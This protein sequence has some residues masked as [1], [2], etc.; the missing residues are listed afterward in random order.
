M[1]KHFETLLKAYTIL[2]NLTP[3]KYDCGTLCSSL[4]CKNNSTEGETLGMWLLPYEK[5]L[6]SA[7]ISDDE[8][9]EF[10]F[11]KA[12]DGTE[13]VFCSGRCNRQFRPFACRIYPYYVN[14]TNDLSGGTKVKIKV[15][16]RAKLSCP[17]A[18]N[19]SYLRPS[20]H[21][22][23]GVKDAVRVL[24]KDEKIKKDLIATS[25]FLS[26]IEEMQNKLLGI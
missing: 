5:E 8:Q 16:P 14:F 15:D 21:F 6:L 19:D 22:I 4:C 13:T 1:L 2:E 17:I 20:I 23:K 12:E 7:L 10:T 3:L 18:M 9:T 24:I 25:E 26:E 11:G